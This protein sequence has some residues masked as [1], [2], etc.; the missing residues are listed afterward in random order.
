MTTTET[1]QRAQRL[2]MSFALFLDLR[3]DPFGSGSYL[4]RRPLQVPLKGPIGLVPG[5]GIYPRGEQMTNILAASYCFHAAGQFSRSLSQ[6]G[7]LRICEWIHDSLLGFGDRSRPRAL[8]DLRNEQYV[9]HGTTT[10]FAALDIANGRVLTQCRA[11][12]RHQG[13]LGFLKH[14][15]ANVP[16]TLDA[17]LVVDNYAAHKHPKCAPGSPPGRAS[18]CTSADLR[19]LA[20]SGRA[21]VRHFGQSPPSCDLCRLGG[22]PLAERG[23]DREQGITKAGDP[24]VRRA[25]IEVA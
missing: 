21:L 15:D 16:A 23:T 6:W 10:L 19:I 18:I 2:S 8:A 22:E 14:I 5:C 20:Q 4:R 3:L 7:A 24:R 11:R 13:F 12:H 25:M 17:H 9:R 1:E